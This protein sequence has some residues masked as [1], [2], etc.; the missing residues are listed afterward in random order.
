MGTS[1]IAA[2]PVRLGAALRGRRL[3]HPSGV[4]AEGLLERVAPDGEGLPMES[5][6]V[7]G[8]VSKGVGS[9]GSLPDVAGLAWRMP[10]P[11]DLHGCT[12]WDVLLASTL[13]GSRVAL[14]PI[15]G[16]QGATFSSLMPLQY[17]GAAWWVR[18]KLATPLESGGLSLQTVRDQIDS[19]GMVFD[20]DQAPRSGQFQP[21]ARLTLRHLDPSSDD[22]AFDPTMH[23]DPD[24]TLLPRW[25]GE[26]RRAAYRRSRE[27]RDAQ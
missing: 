27:G 11:Q 15:L 14:A 24:V 8:R 4:R 2:L 12:P 13:A 17:R 19:D 10:P 25:L 18:A 1:D 9:P 22:I 3:F 23:S 20:I 16:W 21:L 5:C 6:D 7:I 26:F